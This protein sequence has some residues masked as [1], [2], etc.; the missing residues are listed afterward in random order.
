MNG[1]GRTGN[2]V[3]IIGM[4]GRFPGAVDI[5]RFWHNLHEGLESITF[6]SAEELTAAGVDP[7]VITD[8]RFVPAVPAL[9]EI[10]L[11]DAGFFGLSP[12][13]AE[14]MDPQQR[15]LL[16]C[17]WT[18]LED[19]GYGP[20]HPAGVAGVYAGAGISHYL[21][22]NLL[23]D[24]DARNTLDDLQTAI[25][26]DRDY[27]ST[28]VSYELDLEGPSV[29]VQ[30]AC[31]TSLVA[32]HL[33]CQG[34]LGG[35]CDLALAGGVSLNL[36]GSHG[37]FWQKDGI[38]SPDGHC[39]AFDA[40]AQGTVFGSGAGLVVLKRLD[41]ALADGDAIRAVI[42]GSAVNNDGGSR[43]GF[44]APRAE[45]QAK[46]IRA[47]L[48]AA[49]VDAATLS[50]V[51]AHGTGTSLGDPIEIDALTR[52]FRAR[53]RRTGFCAIGAVKTNVGHL[54]TA[55]GVAGLIKTVLALQH[56]Q[57][58]R[59]LHYEQPNP[60]I[61]FAA[62]PFY[63]AQGGEWLATGPRRA[64]VSSFGIGGTNAHVVL[65]EAPPASASPAGTRPAQILV[66]SARSEAALEKAT[67]NLA[68]FLA[69]HPET[70]LADVAFTLQ[71]GRWAFE[72]RRVLVCRDTAEAATALAA[73]DP[74][75]VLTHAG[76]PRER[77]VAFLFPGQG[78]Q[79]TGMG[80]GLYASE[81]TFR[82]QF[83]RGA[84][85]LR[86]LLGID[87]RAVLYPPAGEEGE[88]AARLERTELA[89]PALFVVEHA[90]ARLWLEWGVRPAAMLGHSVGEYTAAV[91]AKVLSFEDALALLAARGRLMERQPPG[92][93]L[94]LPLGAMEIL[95]R[96]PRELSL[97][98]VNGPRLVVVAGPAGAVEELELQLAAEGIEGRRL[99]TSHAFHSSLMESAVGP[100]LDEVARVRL[101][102]PSIPF[103]SGPTGTWITAEEATDPGYWARHL[104]QTVRFGDG[105]GE[106][107]R[108]PETMLLEVGPG[109]TLVSLVQGHPGR[110]VGQPTLASLP[111]PRDGS[112]DED[113]L[114]GALARLWLAGVV[115]DWKGHHRHAARRR[116]RL[117]TYPFARRRFW[118]GPT[119]LLPGRRPAAEEPAGGGV[120]ALDESGGSAAATSGHER[121][122]LGTSY[123]SPTGEVESRVA[124]VWQ[125]LLGITGIGVHDDFLEL[126]GHSLL[127]TRTVAQLERELGVE[128]SVRDLFAAPTIARLSRLIL[129]RPRTQAAETAGSKQ[130]ALVPDPPHRFDPFPATEVQQ[131]YW[132]GR[133]G[134]FELGNVATHVYCEL[135]GEGLDLARL[136]AACRRL[137]DRHDMLRAVFLP[138]GRQ[139]VLPVVPPYRIE[140]LD[141][142]ALPAGEAGRELERLR[143]EASHQVM[144]SDRWPLFAVRA[145]RLTASRVRLHVSFD[146][147]ITDAWSLALLSRELVRLY[148]E[149][150]AELPPLGATFRDYVLAVAALRDSPQFR[151]SLEYWRRR[152]MDLPPG[153]D[154]PLARDPASIA[155]PRFAR[156]TGGMEAERWQRLKGRAASEGLTPSALLLAAFAEVLAR[157]SRN[158][159]FLITL[160]LFQ[161]LPLHPQIDDIV[162]DFTSLTLLAVDGSPAET[163]RERARRLQQLLIEDLDHQHVSGVRVLRE[164]AQS[165]GRRVPLM[166]VVFTSLLG[167]AETGGEE[168]P[169][170]LVW[171]ISQTPQVWLDHQVTERGGALSWSWDAVEDLFPPELLDDLFAAYGG[172]LHR[173]DG[174]EE[175]W[176]SRPSLLPE[177]QRRLRQAVNATAAALPDLLL[178]EL[179]FAR[180]AE[181]P[182]VPAILAPDR[183]LSYGEL[184]RRSNALARRLRVG[185]ARP[186]RLVAVVMEKGWEQVVA[187]LAILEAGAA[188]LPVDPAQPPERLRHLLERGEVEQA[189][190]QPWVAGSVPW[191]S[192][193]RWLAVTSEDEAGEPVPLERLQSPRD[194]AYVIFTSGSTGSPKGVMIEHRA[195]VNTILDVNRRFAIGPDDRV[196]AL[197]SLSFDL[198]VWDI[199]GLLAAG[200]AIVLSAAS[201]HRSPGRWLELMA[202]GKVTVWNSVPALMEMLVEHAAGLGA[203]LPADLRLV[204]LSGDWIP[205]GLPDRLRALAGGAQVVSLGGATEASIWSVFHPISE[206]EASWS[207]IPY[208]RP[209][210]NQRFHVLDEALADC[211]DWVPGQLHIAGEGLAR[212]YWR[213]GEKTAASFFLHPRTG[214]RLYRTGDLGRYLP[215]GTLEFL[216]REDFQV[217]VQGYRIE[218]GEIEAAL[219]AH[220]AVRAAVVS[221]A[222]DRHHRRLIAYV[223]GDRAAVPEDDLRRFLAAKLPA[224]MIPATLIALD[225]L[226]LTANG[227]VDRAALPVSGEGRA[228][229]A[230]PAAGAASPRQQTLAAI[231]AEVLGTEQVAPHDNFF[232]LGGDSILAIQVVARATRAGLTLS[233]EQIFEHPTLAELA[234][235]A[236]P[237]KAA[238]PA[239]VTVSGPVPLTP[240]QHWFFEHR[241]AA[242]HHWN[243][244]VFLALRRPVSTSALRQS[245]DAVVAHHDALRLRFAPGA[246]GWRQL[247]AEAEG[248][249]LAVIDLSGLGGERHRGELEAIAAALQGT[250]GLALGPLLRAALFRCGPEHQDRLLLIIHHLVVDGLSWRILLEDLA[251]AH[252]QA[253]R[254]LAPSLPP[255]T[256]SFRRW[257]ERLT[258]HAWLGEHEDELGEWLAAARSR[259][260]PLPLDGPGGESENLESSVRSVAVQL[261]VEETEIL[262]RTVPGVHRAQIQEVLLTAL[263]RALAP[264]VG[265][266]MLLIDVETH[267]RE[268]LF[269]DLDISR[270]VGWFTA[271]YPLLLE[272]DPAAGAG[273]TLAAVKEQVRRVP[274][275]GVGYGILR[276]LSPRPEVG[277]RLAALPR[278]GIAFNYLGQLD[279]AVSAQSAFEAAAEDTGPW[280]HP[281][282]RRPHALFVHGRI[283]EGRLTVVWAYS[284]QMHRDATV[285]ALAES[286]RAALLEL[287]HGGAAVAAVPVPSD[288]PLVELSTAELEAAFGAIEFEEG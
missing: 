23:C 29:T 198:S 74:E 243:Q 32:V 285:T 281:R 78:A 118:S 172:L 75:R 225:E 52:V 102:A 196:L 189:L 61:D 232:T 134:S 38:L 267:G 60:R 244:A 271:V 114:L 255:K 2:E 217:K 57:I 245:F 110:S 240:I 21:L 24:P 108:E 124:A 101:R 144:P 6:L 66:L 18:A 199:L 178:H 112:T 47:A 149:P 161:R 185:G 88:A 280:N 150:E 229:P 210:A 218:L 223:V 194:L 192:G 195:A 193:V 258:E 16:E 97:A 265:D 171:S 13:E 211:P 173:L 127:A 17:A 82:E 215:D 43:M 276:Y 137:I 125:E 35:D 123:Q 181:R 153:P 270:T 141:L 233:A 89:Q 93:M 9:A 130:A 107:F 230:V 51:E 266:G 15:I 95:P 168:L 77:P 151:R 81:P 56:R 251:A 115:V 283:A 22:S 264:W 206:V 205:L 259:V 177:R 170:E 180:A 228:A 155:R 11:F 91:L 152:L 44:T 8:P 288:F 65:E 20:R 268:G 85:L 164:L 48:E 80:R 96:L 87:L 208:G 237:A 284:E 222:G 254:G 221:A 159:R 131:A 10:D 30:T 63:V 262:L 287:V 3:A 126:G 5:D 83:D 224:Y 12:R 53:T 163:F 117:P 4:A 147:L 207:S 269:P 136:E 55:A 247:N 113:V 49:A 68:R 106:L 246:A 216:G 174:E 59:T 234:E 28:R 34:L 25:G 64:G 86:P 204:L 227:K 272:V 212:G 79:H 278:A 19:A 148:R 167:M 183:T 42:L 69:E 145:T 226:P 121:P 166:P 128:L 46:V 242:P 62:S 1:S 98:A 158:S 73:R 273:E 135:E 90:L 84:E 67:D 190:T 162:G 99:H 179:F 274:R 122:V 40:R 203:C 103:L 250:L 157:W 282:L 248:T 191:P 184:R 133:G 214:E 252:D 197:S 231:W 256:A 200:G 58:P 111:H 146:F 239:A 279:Q 72:H 37:Y 41:E 54:N 116:V 201:A 154:L 165:A 39:R 140:L 236:A 143:R 76:E 139:Q 213:D 261:S 188:Y 119:A 14:G 182:E 249:T 45:G 120:P 105:L 238:V 109:R 253:A 220:P 33:A 142:S 50:Y 175:V 104:R 26:N 241:F 160:T 156:R 286:F 31:S 186:D 100:F 277:E 260:R 202:E 94:S 36:H 235:L 275:A 169:L 70:P 257:A 132:V 27:V 176:S 7:A 71:V 263:A 187:V 138:D 219:L 92:S 209:M 129:D